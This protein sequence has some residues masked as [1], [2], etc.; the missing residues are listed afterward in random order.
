MG[1]TL[2][3]FIGNIGVILLLGAYLLLQL[4]KISSTQIIYSLLNAVGALLIVLSLL[5]DFNLSALVM[6]SLWLLI[7]MFGVV[8]YY[9]S[10][11][12]NSAVPTSS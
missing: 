11:K 4:N 7:S 6:E 3:D 10:K 2:Y 12:S 1:Y 5:I 8:N 9:R